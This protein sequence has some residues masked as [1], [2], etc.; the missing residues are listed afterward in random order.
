MVIIFS[1]SNNGIQSKKQNDPENVAMLKL[2]C[3]DSTKFMHSRMLS[4]A[5][6]IHHHGWCVLSQSQSTNHKFKL[7]HRQIRSTNPQKTYQK[8]IMIPNELCLPVMKAI[9]NQ[10]KHRTFKPFKIRADPHRAQADHEWQQLTLH[11]WSNSSWL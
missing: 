7:P 8:D 4:T 3:Q 2:H 10:E 5:L 9:Y 6:T 11:K 1:N